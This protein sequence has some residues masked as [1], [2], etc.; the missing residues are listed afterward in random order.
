MALQASDTEVT[1]RVG[2]LITSPWPSPGRRGN[3]G[4]NLR[5]AARNTTL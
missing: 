5:V 2:Y 4:R 1:L 3:P